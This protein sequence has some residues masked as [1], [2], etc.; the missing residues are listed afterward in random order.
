MKCHV[1]WSEIPKGVKFCPF[2]GLE[3]NPMPIPGDAEHKLHDFNAPVLQGTG[4]G[5]RA[6]A[7]FIDGLILL[8]FFVVAAMFGTISQYGFELQGLGYY[9]GILLSFVYFIFLEGKFGVT[10]GKM[11]VGLKVI[12]SDGSPCDLHAA[13][14]RT[15]CRLVDGIFCYLVGAIF[16][17][18]SANKQ[19]LGDL[20]ADTVVIKGKK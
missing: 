7:L 1:C 13:A 16:I 20:I 6:V 2:C 14:I 8:P 18:T 3:L 11:A 15:I 5:L 17:W 19:R 9:S 10:V 12:R 4:V